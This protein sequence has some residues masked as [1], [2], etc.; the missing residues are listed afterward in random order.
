MGDS[1][2]VATRPR[3]GRWTIWCCRGMTRT[4]RCGK[5]R[6][7]APLNGNEAVTGKEAAHSSLE[8]AQGRLVRL[9]LYGYEWPVQK[10]PNA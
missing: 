9:S 5:R 4:G 6:P 2:T 3:F 1:L 10:S 7:V 8:S